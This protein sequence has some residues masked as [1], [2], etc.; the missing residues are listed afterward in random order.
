MSLLSLLAPAR[1]AVCAVPGAELCAGCTRLLPR[2]GPTGCARC[3]APGPWPVARCVECS[4]RRLGF[5]RA[6]GVLVYAGPTRRLLAS[7]KE[8]GRRDLTRLLVALVAD[9]V[10]P[11][12]VDVVTFVPADR[13]RRLARGFDPPRA[14]AAGVAG[15]WETQVRPLLTR[16][17]TGSALRQAGLR[18]AERRSNVRGAFTACD[19]APP[20]VLLVDDVYTTGS[21]VSACATELRRAGARSVEVVCLARA[22]R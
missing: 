4:G 11:P 16:V 20:R 17:A 19:R 9:A 6:R 21:T 2:T 3:G 5:A 7:W 15:E 1:C 10:G 8:R 12:Q 18:G 13:E 14:L 22:V